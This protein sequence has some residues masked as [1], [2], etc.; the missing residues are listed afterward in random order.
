MDL[1]VNKEKGVSII[2]LIITVILLIIITGLV[3]YTG[4]EMIDE[5]NRA[6]LVVN[7]SMI[8]TKV[9]TINEKYNFEGNDTSVFI[10]TKMT[11]VIKLP[12]NIIKMQQ[13]INEDL[14]LY[15]L[16]TNDDLSKMNLEFIKN[17]N[18]E[19]IYLVNY[20]TNEIIYINGFKYKSDNLLYKL[21]DIRNIM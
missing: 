10:G 4:M 1:N 14:S 15:Y 7:M 9:K 12:E 5:V 16:L 21:S 18:E 17:R 20:T 13:T 6:E 2:T 3:V 8:Q 19:N 11:D